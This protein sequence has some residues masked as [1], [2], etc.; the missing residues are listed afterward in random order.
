MAE[1]T[2][3]NPSAE[4]ASF[5]TLSS[6]DYEERERWVRDELLPHATGRVETETGMD[7]TFPGTDRFG[8]TLRD[9]VEHERDCCTGS[10]R[11]EAR[12]DADAWVLVVIGA[13]LREGGLERLPAVAPAPRGRVRRALA[14]GGLG[15]AGALALFCG[16]PLAVAA[17]LG[18]AA[19]TPLLGLDHPLVVGAG[20]LAFAAVAWRHTRTR[21][22]P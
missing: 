20:A 13:R 12:R 11:F 17:V 14:A 16:V 10:V 18:A 4:G 2:A 8:A 21:D 5:C 15:V 7:I 19:A 9:F 6:R 22:T 1:S 3:T